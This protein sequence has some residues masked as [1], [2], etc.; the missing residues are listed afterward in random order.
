MTNSPAAAEDVAQD[1]FLALLRHPGRFD[2]RRGSLRSFLF[3][4]ARNL[5]LKRWREEH[6]WEPL[7][8]D[9]FVFPAAEQGADVAEVIG[10][11]VR[12][13]PPLQRE[14]LILAE[15]EQMSLE[16]IA[17]AVVAEVGTV[18]SRLYRA[19]ENLR[20]ALAPLWESMGRS[21]NHHGTNE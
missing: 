17:S 11:A 12:A 2:G 19:R 18:K 6:R 21:R 16:E 9:A 1:A 4:V 5:V 15:Y 20:S 14:A 8:D 13:L 7:D 3:G 10:A